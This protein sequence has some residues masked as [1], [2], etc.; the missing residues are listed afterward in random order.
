MSIFSI[1]AKSDFPDVIISDLIF[2][3]SPNDGETYA[4]KIAGIFGYDSE[5]TNAILAEYSTRL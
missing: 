5:L 1:I 2:A 4:E 3:I